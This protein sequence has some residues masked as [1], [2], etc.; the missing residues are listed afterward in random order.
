MNGAQHI[1]QFL[2]SLAE[3]IKFAE[4]VVLTVDV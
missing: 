4:D 3:S 2:N 1:F